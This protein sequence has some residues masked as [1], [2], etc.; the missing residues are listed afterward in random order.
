MSE[1][2]LHYIWRFQLWNTQNLT[3]V[4]GQELN[5]ISTGQHNHDSGP[6]F[7][8]AK[9]RI[10]KT[11]WAGNVEIHINSSD[12]VKHQHTYDDAYNN[13]ILHVVY[14]LDKEV[15]NSSGQKIP[16]LHAG[17]YLNDNV[18]SKYLSLQ[19]NLWIACG[20]QLGEVDDFI[21][22]NWLERLLIERLEKKTETLQELMNYT[23][24]DWA[25]TFYIAIA[26]NFGFTANQ[27]PFEQLAKSIKQSIIARHRKSLLQVEALLFGS[28]GLLLDHFKDEYP[29]KLISEFNIL[30]KKY[31]ISPMEGHIWKFLRMRPSNFPTIRLSQFAALITRTESLFSRLIHAKDLE[32]MRSLFNVSASE[33]W[34]SHY[35]FDKTSATVRMKKLGTFTVDMLLINTVLPFLFLYGKIKGDDAFAMHALSLFEKLPAENNAIIRKWIGFGIKPVSALQSQA[36]LELRKNYC[37]EKKCLNCTIGLKILDYDR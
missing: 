23:G 21:W 4:D 28:A 9:I 8:N 34:N 33:Y 19:K 13:V 36:L 17:Q 5:V 27:M 14:N 29:R 1:E 7:F 22:R 20:Y 30:Q 37:V 11:M 25:E 2:F 16:A 24:D 31:G 12:W 10:G 35:S 18:Y 3:T 6:D 32:E 15:F 26:K